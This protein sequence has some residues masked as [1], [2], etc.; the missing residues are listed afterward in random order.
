ML[1]AM[2]ID[3]TLDEILKIIKKRMKRR[4][5]MDTV[6]IA[7]F[8][9]PGSTKIKLEEGHSKGVELA[10]SHNLMCKNIANKFGGTVIKNMGDGVFIEFE[11][12]IQACKAALNIKKATIEDGRFKTKGGITLGVVEYIEIEGIRDL[13]GSTIDRCARLAS[14]AIPNQI[15]IDQV[16]FHSTISVLNDW[17]NVIVSDPF[18]IIAKGISDLVAY[19]LSTKSSGFSGFGLPSIQIIEEGRIPLV[20]KMA[21]MLSAKEEIIELGIGLSSFSNLYDRQRPSE[22][23]DK[24]ISLLKKGVIVKC[25]ILNPDSDIAKIYLE[26][27][28]ELNY[29]ER[30]KK[31]LKKLLEM[32]K[33]FQKQELDN[34]K[35][36]MYDAI[37]RFHASCIDIDKQQG[38]ISISQYLPETLRSNNPVMRFSKYSNPLLYDK[39]KSVIQNLLS[40][41]VEI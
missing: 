23:K 24:L 22:F 8:D 16:V 31:S 28:K 11:N 7:M 36:L 19:E 34:F 25:V 41:T 29:L 15:L 3:F 33:E 10:L 6:A 26:D 38:K 18:P 27:N 21:F 39:Y 1:T 13:L 17:K 14:M 37:P 12:T 5:K 40:H 32:K 4:K 9:L 2:M 30:M 20:D 35:I